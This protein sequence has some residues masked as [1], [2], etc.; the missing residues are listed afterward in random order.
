MSTAKKA[1]NRNNSKKSKETH[2]HG[3][4]F[5]FLSTRVN[6]ESGITKAVKTIISS[7]VPSKP[8][9]K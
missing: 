4:S 6:K 3:N 1:I 7:E 9:E 2:I 8:N 5:F